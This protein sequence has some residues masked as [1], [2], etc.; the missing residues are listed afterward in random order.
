MISAG[1]GGLQLKVAGNIQ[2]ISATAFTNISGLSASV[3]S[4][5]VYQVDGQILYRMS[6]ANGVAFAITFPA[7]TVAAGRMEGNTS[8]GQGDISVL[9][10]AG[11]FDEAGSGSVLLSLN[12][13][14]TS[15]R[16]VR[17]EGVFQVSTTAGTIQI[18]SKVSAAA[19]PVNIQKGSYLRAYK[20]G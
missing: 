6:V 11:Y 14:S 12:P 10:V 19:A 8:A 2:K 1:L 20:V 5:A 18:Q 17:F 9:Y 16:T 13:A 4:A 7:G 15:T 3:A